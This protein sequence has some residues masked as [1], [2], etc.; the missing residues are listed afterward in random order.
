MATDIDPEG[1]ETAALYAAAGFRDRRVLE[2]GC[3]PGR[4]TRRY[5]ATSRYVIGVD[6]VFESVMTARAE[7][8]GTLEKRIG[9]VHGS[10]ETLPFDRGRFDI[11][12]FGWSL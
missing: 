5:A 1:R 3:G 8:P 12:L 4:L 6:S 11:V 9:Y 2:I 10:G 7:R